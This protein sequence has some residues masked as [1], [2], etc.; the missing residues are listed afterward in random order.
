MSNSFAFA[1]LAFTI[2]FFNFGLHAKIL[3]D[4]KILDPYL[5]LGI[6]RRPKLK[7]QIVKAKVAKVTRAKE[8]GKLGSVA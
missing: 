6:V 4:N 5:F 7:K 1:T 3:E 8:L 2:C